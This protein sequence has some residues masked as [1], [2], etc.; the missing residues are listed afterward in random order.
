M[1]ENFYDLLEV[2]K[3]A[4]ENDIKK[5]Y[6]KAAM[7]YHPD[8]NTDN[9]EAAEAKF[10]KIS[11]AYNVL[12][13]KTKKEIYDR[14]G[15]EGL[16]RH[17]SGGGAQGNPFHGAGFNI[18][19]EMFGHG[20]HPFNHGHSP[21]QATAK[22]EV[23]N[24]YVSLEDL[25]KGKTVKISITHTVM[26]D[27]NNISIC[28]ECRGRGIQVTI[29]RFGP[30]IQQSQTVCRECGGN[31]KKC[32]SDNLK[33]VKKIITLPIAKGTLDGS[34]ILLE[35]LANFNMGT[36]KND[37]LVFVIK[38]EKHKKFIRER[39]DLVYNLDINLID[40]L[41]GFK[42]E[43]VHLDNSKFIIDSRSI[44]LQG[45]VK[46]LK[47]KGMPYENSPSM[48]GNL[49]IKFNILYPSSIDSK[50]CS[51]LKAILP[52]SKFPE[53][54]SD[55]GPNSPNPFSDTPIIELI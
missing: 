36:M 27:I 46:T 24:I 19:E 14:H 50:D 12:T 13:D 30:M 23:K 25:Y 32:N 42:Y 44:I 38:E 53:L 5:A 49:K 40:S 4:S 39:N 29:R 47:N 9:K 2:S 54:N 22:T 55:D 15:E 16:E 52:K 3:N 6:K 48:S 10:K 41:I 17:E 1:G 7:K 8:K 35:G 28:Q 43:F 33:E 18:F 51:K 21:G 11:N 26:K 34:K 31:G 20:G 45:D 37:D